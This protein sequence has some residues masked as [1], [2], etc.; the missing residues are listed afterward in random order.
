M[1]A[2][3]PFLPSQTLLATTILISIYGTYIALSPPNPPSNTKAAPAPAPA[4]RDTIRLG[5]GTSRH[6]TKFALSPFILLGI[7]TSLLA[8]YYPSIP[9][10]LVKPGTK[11]QNGPIRA[12]DDAHFMVNPDLITWSTGT[13]L[14]LLLILLVGIP[15]RLKSYTALGK[16]FTFTLAEPDRLVTAGIYRYVQHPSY[17]GI[18]ALVFGNTALLART[19][20]AVS[21]W[22]HVGPGAGLLRTVYVLGLGSGLSLVLWAIWTRVREEERML[23]GRFGEEWIRWHER[24]ARSL[25]GVF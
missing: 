5:L 14:P 13:V 25:P 15:L 6:F 4:I 24:T 2:L 8:L 20:G 23:R 12:I 1:S 19:D 21:C 3:P 11:I 9:A 7:H 17:V 22:I 18:L 16:N 10:W